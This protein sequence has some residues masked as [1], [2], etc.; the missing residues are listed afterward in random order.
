MALLT[1]H[2]LSLDALYFKLMENVLGI[3]F[4]LFIADNI[5]KSFELWYPTRICVLENLD[6]YGIRS[7]TAYWIDLNSDLSKTNDFTYLFCHIFLIVQNF[8]K[9]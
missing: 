8:K 3:F 7:G 4:S 6:F 9:T 1:L 2:T 5:L